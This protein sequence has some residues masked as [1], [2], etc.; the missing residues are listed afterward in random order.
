[1]NPDI[2]SSGAG[3]PENPEDF[4]FGYVALIG[5][6]NVG[7]STLMNAVLGQKVSIVTYKPQTTRQRVAGIKT[8]KKGQVVYLDTPG[9]HA[10]AGRALNRYM[11]RVAKATFRD[12]EL[13]LFLLEAGRYTR[14]DKAIA[15]LLARVEV[16]VF[17]VV[18]KVDTIGDK[19]TLLSYLAEV[20]EGRNYDEVLLVSA[21]KGDGVDDLEQHILERLP[22]SMPFYDEDQIT[23]RSE[24]FLA[25][26]FLREALTLRLHQELPYSLTVDIERFKRE[27]GVLHI[28]AVIWV[29]RE[30]QK[31]I[32]IGK[33]G[34]AL[35]Q[36][37]REARQAMEELF[38]EKVFLETWVKVSRDWSRSDKMLERFGFED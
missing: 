1:M 22:F 9:I 20:T 29:E 12:V 6:P 15:K 33:G 35:K 36:V 32:V 14:Q 37:G 27:N 23:D 3:N 4:R 34:Q 18:N 8:T 13:V 2:E 28:N 30:S 31:Q 25:A 21:L 5:R 24:R 7:K 10:S 19:A 38:G 16:P 17:L 26:E 11:N